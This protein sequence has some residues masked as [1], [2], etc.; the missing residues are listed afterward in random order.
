MWAP[1][2]ST[3]F[4]RRGIHAADAGGE[5]GARLGVEPAQLAV[6]LHGQLARGRHDQRQGRGGRAEPL[7]LAQQGGGDRQSI[8]HRLAGARLGRGQQV[9]VAAPL[10]QHGPLH[11]RGFEIVVSGERA[12]ERGIDRRKGHGPV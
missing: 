7:R 10:L 2:A 11:G 3:R 4:S 8:A 6:H 12:R 9:A 1:S 5:L